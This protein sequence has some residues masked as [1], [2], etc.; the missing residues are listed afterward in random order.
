M[1]VE[2]EE[3]G[4]RFQWKWILRDL[5]LTIR[6]RSRWA[7]TGPN[8]SGKS[9]LL[10]MLCGHL[11]PSRGRLSFHCREETIEALELYREVA[12]AAPYI[13]LIEEFT[14]LEALQFHQKFKPLAQGLTARDIVDLLGFE[15]SVRQE[16]RYFSSGMKQRLKLALAFCSRASL[17]LLD[18]PT[19][20]LDAQGSQ[21]YLQLAE[22]F[23][24]DQTIV[25]ASNM[26][27]DFAFCDHQLNVLD[28][29]PS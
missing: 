25:V 9:T 12:F 20:N 27:S 26:P 18:E 19:T 14:L 16:I 3:V 2:L 10:K 5:N 15:K 24:R 7:V 1:R 17:L 23:A 6:P 13:E 29:K 21:W 28:Y 8:G 11:S 4:K 22:R